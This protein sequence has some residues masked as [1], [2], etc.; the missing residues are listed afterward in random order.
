MTKLLLVLPAL[1][2]QF[3]YVLCIANGGEILSRIT[4]RTVRNSQRG[5]ALSVD[6]ARKLMENDFLI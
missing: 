5:Q 6:Y 2:R 1:G 3:P 4:Q